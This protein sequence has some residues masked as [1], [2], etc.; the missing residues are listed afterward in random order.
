MFNPAQRRV[1]VAAGPPATATVV[2]GLQPKMVSLIG[3]QTAAVGNSAAAAGTT[4][5]LAFGSSPPPPPPPHSSH[6]H[7]LQQQQQLGPPSPLSALHT[8][9]E[10]GAAGSL[11]VFD[12]SSASY[13]SPTGSATTTG[14]NGQIYI[15]VRQSSHG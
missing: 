2:S 15:E 13:P 4:T 11:I 5:I 6:H 7:H 12:P 8:A 10:T 1:A 3:G 14:P 9:T